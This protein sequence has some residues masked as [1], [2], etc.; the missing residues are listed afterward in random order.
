M[1]FTIK[2]RTITAFLLALVLAAG[3]GALV[4]EASR[5]DAPVFALP[6]ANHVVLIDAGH[7]GRDAGASDNGVIEKEIN[8]KIALKLQGYIEQSGGIAVLTRDEDESTEDPSRKDSSSYKKSD[9]TARVEA[10]EENK[11]DIYVSIHMNKFN[12]SSR[13]SQVFYSGNDDKS[14]VLGEVIQQ[15]LKDVLQDGNTRSA[16][17]SGSSIF[18]LKNATVPAV[19]VECGFLSNKE[20]ARL[21]ADEAYQSK[22][23]WAIYLGITK[24]FAEN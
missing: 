13:G 23:A 17:K 6:S 14:R 21:L 19:L 8:L 20:E 16:K 10:A 18:V 2:R 5:R 22:V 11:A 4:W 1:F 12:L 9:L 7:G 3:V 24:Y 15:S